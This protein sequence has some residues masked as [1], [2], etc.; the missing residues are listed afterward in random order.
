LQIPRRTHR[1]ALNALFFTNQEGCCWRA[2]RPAAHRLQAAQPLDQ[3]GPA[4]GGCAE[5]QRAQFESRRPQALS[6]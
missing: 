1:E 3:A 5:L 6:L 2:L 4:G